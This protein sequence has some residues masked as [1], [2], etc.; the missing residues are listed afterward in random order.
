M[1]RSTRKL[2][3]KHGGGRKSAAPSSGFKPAHTPSHAKKSP[4][5]SNM[6]REDFVPVTMPA[7]PKRPSMKKKKR[8]L[9]KVVIG[10]LIAVLVLGAGGAAA[11]A[12]YVN[13]LNSAIGIQDQE[14]AIAIDEVLSPVVSDEP[15]YMMI[16]G[17][18]S[19]DDDMGQ[20]SDTNIVAR[21]D[22]TTSTITLI[23][24]PR[25]TAI[26]IDGNV[27]KFNAA[28]NYDG[29][30]GAIEA[31]NELLGVKMSHYVEVDFAGLVDLID[32]V[33]GV[34]VDVP[35]RIEDADAGG[36]IEAGV[37]TLDGEDALIFARSRSYTTGDFQR[38][39]NQ[40]IL[41]EGFI[42]KVM[43]IPATE[44]PGLVKEVAK[45]ITTDMDLTDILGYVQMFQDSENLTI[46][47]TMIPS[48]TA[49]HN[50]V[51]YVVCDIASL[52]KMMEVVNEGGDP[53]SVV[54][55][56]TISSSEEAEEL[57]ES[58]IPI[59]VETDI[60]NGTIQPTE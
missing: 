20:R 53:S 12:L 32:S 36:T 39:T 24:I 35:M 48:T 18:D 3:S 38:S 19:R 43:D 33:G 10:I 58:G 27:E 30:Q 44:I 23:S 5:V 41:I 49:D 55:D 21:I 56:E 45:C 9:R 13:Q 50:K 22:P 47:S 8:T 4:N 2:N 28:Y 42:N 31:A 51:S 15:F 54:K 16:I 11:A 25:D 59:Y 7:T 34:E 40:R 26:N 29:A 52:Q 6:E 37:Q 1:P 60:A 46:Y 14:Q 57:G 17:S